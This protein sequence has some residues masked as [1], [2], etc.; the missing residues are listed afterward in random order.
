MHEQL[1]STTL[2]TPLGDMTA[3]ATDT[4]L[5]ALDFNQPKRILLADQRLHKYIQD[6]PIIAQ[7][8]EVLQQTKQWVQRYFVGDFS[9]LP[10]VPM[11]HL[12]SSFETSVWRA[13]LSIPLGQTMSYK[14]L[15]QTIQHPLA[16]RAVGNA[17]R[18]NPL[19]LLVP[20][21]RVIGSNGHLTGYGGGLHNKAWLLLHERGGES[22][23]GLLL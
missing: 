3:Y 9:A 12:G 13:M 10:S 21:H 11:Q 14:D 23:S 17:S 22:K 18:R 15:A 20:C 2:P 16:S 4:A 1:F 7:E 5:I 19:A 6:V 8:N